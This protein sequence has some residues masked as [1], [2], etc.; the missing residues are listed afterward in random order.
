[1]T[2]KY[3][4]DTSIWRDYFE[5]RNDGLRPLGEWAFELIK[6]IIR[7]KDLF[8]YSDVVIQEL[9]KRYSDEDIN[10]IFAVARADNLLERTEARE[11]QVKEARHLLGTEGFLLMM[12]CMLLLQG[13]RRLF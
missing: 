10:K 5:N 7:N 9:R 2:K 11:T 3:Y 12:L 8:L 1:M 4:L 13:M 6:M